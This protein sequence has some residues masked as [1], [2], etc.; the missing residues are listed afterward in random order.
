[1]LSASA[2]LRA[3]ALAE[4]QVY[5]I[6]TTTGSCC[7]CCRHSIRTD[8]KQLATSD[9]LRTTA[10][11]T[12]VTSAQARQLLTFAA[13]RLSTPKARMTGTGMRSRGPPI[14]KFWIERCV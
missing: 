11:A 14:L 2:C 13:A 8:G 1:M 6:E 10:D 4:V 12:M 9:L 3:A 5:L 7:D